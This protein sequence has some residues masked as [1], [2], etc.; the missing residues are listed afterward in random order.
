MPTCELVEV[1]SLLISMMLLKFWTIK[2]LFVQSPE[3]PN[4]TKALLLR[5]RVLT[6]SGRMNPPCPAVVP[7]HSR[8]RIN[9][10][11]ALERATERPM[12]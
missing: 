4:V 11:N 6:L 1:V 5:G 9:Q 7:K 3:I 10:V 12:D 2:V 8:G